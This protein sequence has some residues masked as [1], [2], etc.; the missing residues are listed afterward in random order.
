M[1]AKAGVSVP[2]FRVAGTAKEAV[3]LVGVIG[4]PVVVRP[5]TASGSVGVHLCRDEGDVR[6]YAGQ[7]LESF[8]NERGMVADTRVLIEGYLDGVEH[9]VETFG[10]EVIG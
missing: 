2:A 8:L 7:L 6:G 4:Y 5:L 10:N 9:S 3:S 1:L